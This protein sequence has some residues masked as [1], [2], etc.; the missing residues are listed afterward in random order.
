MIV[1]I[2][3]P[4]LQCVLI[5][6][7]APHSGHSQNDIRS[8]WQQI[9]Q[10]V[11]SKAPQLPVLLACDANAR[12]GSTITDEVGG[13]GGAA[14]NL[15]GACF[16]EWLALHQLW[17]PATF[18]EAHQGPHETYW[19]PDG[20]VAHRLDYIGLASDPRFQA[21]HNRVVEE[22]DLA[23]KR[24]DHLAV[25]C[26]FVF[27]A[28]RHVPRRCPR[29]HEP[30]QIREFFQQGGNIEAFAS[31]LASPS[32]DTSVRSHAT[33]LQQKV[34]GGLPS[35]SKRSLTPRWKRHLS[36]DTMQWVRH[37]AE[38]HRLLLT[39][40]RTQQQ[41]IAR[42]IRH[43]WKFRSQPHVSS[44]HQALAQY[45]HYISSLWDA[46]RSAAMQVKSLA[47]RDDRAFYE[48]LARSAGKT[49]TQQGLNALWRSIRFL[50]PR[51][52]VKRQ[53]VQPD[54]FHDFLR[55]FEQLEGGTTLS[56]QELRGEISADM[57]G[58]IQQRPA[59][60]HFML[61][62]LPALCEIELACLWRHPGRAPGPD[63]HFAASAV[64]LPIHNL[65]LKT[66][67][68]GQE[69]VSLKGGVLQPIWKGKSAL[70]DA[71]G[72]RGILLSNSFAKVTQAWARS[73]LMDTFSRT[74]CEGQLGGLKE[75]QT[76]VAS[77]SLRIFNRLGKEARRSTAVIFLD[78]AS[79]FHCMLRE[80]AF[81]MQTHVTASDMEKMFPADGL[82]DAQVLLAKMRVATQGN[83]HGLSPALRYLLRSLSDWR[84]QNFI[85]R[86]PPHPEPY[87]GVGQGAPW[88]M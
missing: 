17:L 15:S 59:T 32:W 64:A 46:W 86:P 72:F 19:S 18:S 74:A 73:K 34:R 29:Q 6:T 13:F 83:P 81:L 47:R 10:V 23:T 42:L 87:E 14:E 79:A 77:R 71:T 21:V 37:K 62:D 50:L 66:V 22:I 80:W 3:H 44:C 16:R 1:R 69:A 60:E 45:D 48:D 28:Q 36:A 38:L 78:L 26:S 31:C 5:N 33:L 11:T 70:H 63:A 35:P 85:N 49:A 30:G 57:T 2:N 84:E 56:D 24:I 9:T 20:S 4:D 76:I 54:L 25:L 67:L 82:I 43:V 55:H 12:S 53:N 7:H 40:R 8:H 75:R 88:L 51:H 68:Q 39:S 52:R 65:A 61:S 27:S 41:W 58:I